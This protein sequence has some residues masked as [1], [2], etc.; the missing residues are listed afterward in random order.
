MYSYCLVSFSRYFELN[1][2]FSSG[3][4]KYSEKLPPFL[5]GRRRLVVDHIMK[6]HLQAM[7]HCQEDVTV[8]EGG[9]FTV[10]SQSTDKH[11]QCCFFFYVCVKTLIAW[12]RKCP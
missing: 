5:R 4:G 7:S 8:H 2:K 11:N 12:G 6:P 10:K 1:V 3:Y 9:V